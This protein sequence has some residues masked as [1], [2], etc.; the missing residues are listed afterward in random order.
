MG[1]F[2]ATA[3]GEAVSDAD[4]LIARCRRGE[5]DALR[6]LF[7]AHFDFVHRVARRFGTPD[8]EIEDACQDAFWVAVRKLDAFTTGRFKTW[9]YRITANV[10]SDRHRRR[11][12]RR[13]LALLFGQVP[14]PPVPTPEQGFERGE[15]ERVVGL[16]LE[17]MSPKKREVFVLYELEGLSGREIAERVGCTLDNVWARLHHARKEFFSI[18]RKKG[19]SPA[20][21]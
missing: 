3:Q 15:A 2:S 21:E 9:L 19:L 5:Q 16:I 8:D 13:K 17:R 14:R 18:A 4:L 12:S 6:T 20:V 10:V 1:N 11:R 7:Q